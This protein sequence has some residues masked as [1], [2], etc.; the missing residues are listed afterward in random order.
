MKFHNFWPFYIS[1]LFLF[2]SLNNLFA[3][4]YKIKFFPTPSKNELVQQSIQA[5]FQDQ[6]GF[7]WIGTQGGLHRYDGYKYRYFTYDPFNSQSISDNYI[8]FFFQDSLGNVWIGTDNG[9]NLFDPV[10]ESFVHYLHDPNDPNSLSNSSIWSIV[11]DEKKNLWIATGEGLNYFDR[12]RGVFTRFKHDPDDPGSLAENYTLSLCRDYLGNIWVATWK[13]LDR[14][15]QKQGEDLS[16]QVSFEHY[17]HSSSDPDSISSDHVYTIYED[18]QKNLWVGTYD[19]GVNRFDRKNGKFQRYVHDKKDPRTLSNNRI[20]TIFHDRH[21]RL[22]VGTSSGLN[23]WR[24]ESDDFLRFYHSVQNPYSLNDS[25]IRSFYED[26]EGVLWIG[27]LKGINRLIPETEAFQYFFNNP[28]SVHNLSH[29]DIRG[30]LWD[31]KGG[32]WMGTRDGLNYLDPVSNSIRVFR[33]SSSDPHSISDNYVLSIHEDRDGIFWIGTNQGGLNRYDPEIGQFRHFKKE[34]DNPN[35]IAH[36]KIW[37]IHDDKRGSL[38]LGTS[39]GLSKFD[40]KRES[41]T[42]YLGT[43]VWAIHPRKA[44]GLWVGTWGKGFYHFDTERGEIVKG[45]QREHGKLNSLTDN[46]IWSFYEEEDGTLWLGSWSGGLN[47]FDPVSETFKSYREKQ[48]ITGGAVY[49]IEKDKQGKLWLSTNSELVRIDPKTE[50]VER[51]G[52]D[53]GVIVNEFNVGAGTQDQNGNLAFGGIHGPV[54]V[55]IDKL[56]NPEIVPKVVLT[57]FKKLNPSINQL[58]NKGYETIN[59]LQEINLSYRDSLWSFEF[60]NV[61][62]RAPRKSRFAYK[63][64]GYD[65]DWIQAGSRNQAMYTNLDGGSYTFQVQGVASDG[66][67]KG[68]GSSIR[69]HIST[70]PWKSWWAYTLYILSGIGLVVFISWLRIVKAIRETQAKKQELLQKKRELAQERKVSEKLRLVDKVKDEFL[71]K[72]SHELLTPLNG[73]IGIADSFLHQKRAGINQEVFMNLSMIRSSGER[74]AN[75][76]KDILDFSR[77]KNRDLVI[78]TKPVDLQRAV[79]SVT[80]FCKPMVK[81]SGPVLINQVEGGATVMADESRLQQILFNLVGNAIKFC[82]AGC[83]TIGA[84]KRGELFEVFVEDTGVGIPE[85]RLEK[86]FESFEQVDEIDSRLNEGVGLGLSISKKLIEL[87]GGKVWVESRLGEGSRFFFTL[88]ASQ[89]SVLDQDVPAMSEFPVET[90]SSEE[91]SGFTSSL[92]RENYYQVMV[93]DDEVINLQVITNYLADQNIT[94]IRKQSGQEALDYLEEN[95]PDLILLDIMM[96]KLSGYEVCREIRKRYSLLELPVLFLSAKNQVTDTVEGFRAGAND[97]LTKPVNK[98]ELVSRI[99]LQLELSLSM[100]RLK[101]IRS[102]SL[103]I[104]HYQEIEKLFVEAFSHIQYFQPSTF[105]LYYND[106]KLKED[107]GQEI[108]KSFQKKEPL[109]ELAEEGVGILDGINP[110]TLESDRKKGGK[111]LYAILDEASFYFYR[112]RQHSDFTHNDVEYLKTFLHEIYLLRNHLQTRLLQNNPDYFQRFAQI[113]HLLKEILYI[114]KSGNRIHIFNEISEIAK[115]DFRLPLSTVELFFREG[116][117]ERVHRSY[118]IN[119]EKVLGV[120]GLENGSKKVSFRFPK[121]EPIPIGKNYEPR[122]VKKYSSWF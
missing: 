84:T 9:L 96:P 103:K 119:P 21:G 72:T 91:S 109:L 56:D 65:Q 92:Q 77:L 93:V 49:A 110:E 35:S 106:G 16:S 27:T 67:R 20:S 89:V 34:K 25:W 68:K 107:S 62:Y 1:F 29:S 45:Y 102:F 113:Q 114:K 39:L 97:Y 117:F 115:I 53:K 69:I 104:D 108:P 78:N 73:I 76:V 101:S 105:S 85:D 4:P 46:R 57:S 30:I 52:F 120:V 64:E 15:V 90:F 14:I 33:S 94:L 81:E 44:G 12:E 18:R 75:L 100:K 55:D 122:L 40:I 13:G 3:Q 7:L 5:F 79:E 58:S 41:F 70:P 28:K 10:E 87:H 74:L 31:R 86:I 71:A 118:I 61:N 88:P 50:Q 22:W 60:A 83:I 99:Y 95:K 51:F 121:V 17:Q 98:H 111:M 54:L 82:D 80:L 32:L 2:V 26:R 23:L 8:R 19:G 59:T 66:T 24:P 36:N 48:G 47:R 6:N 112:D 11:E 42:N 38:W 43:L 37:A 116:T 63:L